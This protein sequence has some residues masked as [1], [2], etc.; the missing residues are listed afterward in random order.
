LAGGA[1]I[2]GLDELEVSVIFG[3]ENVRFSAG[4]QAFP[5]KDCRILWLPSVPLTG[6][7]WDLIKDSLVISENIFRLNPTVILFPVFVIGGNV[8]SS[9]QIY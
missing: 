2:V 6:V 9:R 8:A 5:E 7:V 1:R 3:V 4:T